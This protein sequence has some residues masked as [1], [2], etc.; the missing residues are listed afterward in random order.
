MILL[1]SLS[2]GVLLICWKLKLKIITFI[3]RDICISN[4]DITI[5]LEVS[6]LTIFVFEIHISVLKIPISPFELQKSLFK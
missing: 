2:K 5:E 4:T 6:V 1:K 3:N